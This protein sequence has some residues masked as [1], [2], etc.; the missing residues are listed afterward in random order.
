MSFDVLKEIRE[1]KTQL[2]YAKNIGVFIGAGSSCAVKIPNIVELTKKIEAEIGTNYDNI[3]AEVKNDLS[4]K[5]SSPT[6][7]DILN[8]IR[9][10]REIT[11]EDT[12]KQ[13]LKIKGNV[14]KDGDD[15]ICKAIYKIIS[16]KEASAD[17]S[18]MKKL[19]AWLSILNQDNKKEIFTTNYDLIIEKSL[20]D[21]G[22]PYFDGFVGSYEPFFYQDGIDSE[23]SNSDLTRNWIRVWK[24]H[25]SLNWFWKKTIDDKQ[26]RVVRSGKI[27]NISAISDEIV[28]YPSR[29][30]YSASRKQP[31]VAY[32]DRLKDFLCKGELLFLVLGFSFSDEHINEIL[33]TALRN[34]SRLSLIVFCYDDASLEKLFALSSSYLNITAFGPKKGIVNGSL[35]EWEFDGTSVKPK[36]IT[37]TFWD[38]TENKCKLGDFNFLVDFLVES[39]G[40]KDKIEGITHGK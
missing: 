39:S 7:E 33:F 23:I 2:S 11:D 14:A 19:L 12:K 37:D 18:K 1:L 29:E 26:L 25:G 34:N 17:R 13:Y 40:R 3:F 27:T 9:Q 10:I 4:A 20:E 32:F 38:Q 5:I 35:V 8:R 16:E 6:I 24:L 22:I 21:N 36:E 15:A 31:Y 30:K 28:I